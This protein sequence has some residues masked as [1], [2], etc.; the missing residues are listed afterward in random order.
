[1]GTSYKIQAYSDIIIALKKFEKYHLNV[2]TNE[3][4]KVFEKDINELYIS[5]KNIINIKDDKDIKDKKKD[6]FLYILKFIE[7]KLEYHEK[8]TDREIQRPLVNLYGQLEY[9]YKNYIKPFQGDY[10][11][12]EP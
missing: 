10:F 2:T 12:Y 4:N 9:F 5:I 11:I 7:E 3:A 6:P 8:N 1:M